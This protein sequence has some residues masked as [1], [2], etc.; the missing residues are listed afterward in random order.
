MDRLAFIEGCPAIARDYH[1]ECAFLR[2]HMTGTWATMTG[3]QQTTYT[4]AD[5]L[6]TT[7]FRHLMLQEPYLRQFY[8]GLKDGTFIEL[9]GADA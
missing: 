9:A 7:V 3:D 1:E 2:G 5:R 4:F 8:A 6:I